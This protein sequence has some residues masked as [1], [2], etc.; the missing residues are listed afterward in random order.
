[1]LAKADV[2]NVRRRYERDLENAYKYAVDKLVLE[3][4][5]VVDSLETGLKME[6]IDQSDAF[7][8]QLRTGMEL[9]LDILLKTL[10]KHG[11]QQIN[12]LGEAFDPTR[13]EA[14]TMQKEVNSK[15]HTV[16]QVVQKGYLLKDRLIRPALVIVAE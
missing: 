3:L 4:L 5:P 2:E 6:R 7:V 13:H 14:M 15:A 8:K 10:R 9:T 12:P 1:M 11:V 16:L